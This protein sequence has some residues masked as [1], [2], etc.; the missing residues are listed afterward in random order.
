MGRKQRHILERVERWAFHF[1]GIIL[2]LAL[3]GLV[4]LLALQV[5]FRFVLQLPLAFTEE[6]SR[7]LFSWLIFVGAARALFVSQHFMV[8][9]VYRHVPASLA[10]IF[11]YLADAA[12]VLLAIVLIYAGIRIM[13]SG[14]T[15]PVLGISMGYQYMALPV[16]M[17]LMAFHGLCFILRGKHIGDGNTE[18]FAG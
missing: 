3:L 5:L 16:G 9:I 18:D 10:A 11:G 2:F 1:E 6:A 12:S 7:L 14:Q 17:V 8:D 15:L 4:V 13:S